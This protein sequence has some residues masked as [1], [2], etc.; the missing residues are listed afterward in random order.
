MMVIVG[1]LL[2]VIQCA[3]R[4]AFKLLFLSS[5]LSCSYLDLNRESMFIDI[6]RESLFI[7]DI[8]TVE[9]MGYFIVT[10]FLFPLREGGIV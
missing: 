7:D 4:Y 3:C 1:L 2:Y 5:I 10:S 8:Q 6:N 9:K